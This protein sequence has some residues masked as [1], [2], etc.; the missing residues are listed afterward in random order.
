MNLRDM[1]TLDYLRALPSRAEGHVV[2]FLWRGAELL[3]IGGTK[4][5]GQRIYHLECAKRAPPW[6]D[7][8]HT[9]VPFDRVSALAC[10][11]EEMRETER[12]CIWHYR[13]PY[14]KQSNPD[15]QQ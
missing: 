3:Y 14:N 1:P 11:K 2:Y 4:D 6:V 10:S 15:C 13:P 5:L 7:G 8:Y 9:I 12:D